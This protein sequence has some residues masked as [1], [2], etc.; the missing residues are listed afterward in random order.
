MIDEIICNSEVEIYK[1]DGNRNKN[2]KHKQTNLVFL[3]FIYKYN[4]LTF[5]VCKIRI[6]LPVYINTNFQC[7]QLLFNLL[8]KLY[9][10]VGQGFWITLKCEEFTINVDY[11]QIL[12]KHSQRSFIKLYFLTDWNKY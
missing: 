9:Y 7:V 6:I 1:G 12:H 2:N 4:M 8:C 5:I 10:I 11:G 3:V